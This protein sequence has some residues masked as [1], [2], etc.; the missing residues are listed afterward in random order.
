MTPRQILLLI[1]A[2]FFSAVVFPQEILTPAEKLNFEQVSSYTDLS[3]YIRQIDA[4]SDL[5]SIEK[6]G[7]SVKGRE[8]NALLFSTSGFGRDAGKIRVLIF[9]Q[10]HG[11]EQSGKEGALL[12]ARELI[13]LKTV[14][15]ST[16]L[17]LPLFRK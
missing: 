8:I 5:V 3:A 7:S 14:T 9:A 13:S 4:Q 2:M 6:T 12:L 10:Q 17:T 1:P 15:F 11:N 16:G